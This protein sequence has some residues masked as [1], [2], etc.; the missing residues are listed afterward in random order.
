MTRANQVTVLMIT[1]KF[2]EV[3]AFA[4]ARVGTAARQA[5]AGKDSVADL[6]RPPRWRK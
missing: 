2:R 1:H 5:C 4:D 3:M 6:S